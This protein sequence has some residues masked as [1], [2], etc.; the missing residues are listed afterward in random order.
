METKEYTIYELIMVFTGG[1]NMRS[2]GFFETPEK[3]LIF[4]KSRTSEEIIKSKPII[5][6]ETELIQVEL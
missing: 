2:M 5:R 1:G 6:K 3:A 4:F